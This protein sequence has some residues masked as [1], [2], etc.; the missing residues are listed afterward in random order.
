MSDSGATRTTDHDEIRAWAEEHDGRPATVRATEEDGEPG[1][2]RIAFG[3][4]DGGDLE[5]ISWDDFFARFEEQGLALLY[6]REHADGSDST[7]QRF[8]AR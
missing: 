2:L 4:Q 5:E 7:F 1:I 3:G 6:Q 8:V